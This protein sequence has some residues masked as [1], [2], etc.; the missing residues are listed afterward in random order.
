MPDPRLV[1]L[2]HRLRNIAAHEG[3]PPQRVRN[4]YVFQRVL[5]RLARDP[6]WVLK[7]GFSLELRLGLAARTTKDLDLLR[8]DVADLSA[9]DLQDLLDAALDVDLSDD[10]TFT[11]R[12]PRQVRAEDEMPSTWRVVVD[13][14]VARR[15]FETVTIDV[16]TSP[17]EPT[18]GLDAVAVRPVLGGKPFSVRS[19]DLPRHAAEKTHAYARIY[20]HDRPSSR[21]KDLVDLALLVEQELLEPADYA[22]AVTGVFAERDA[23][24]PPPELPDPPRDWA[25]PFAAMAADIGLD[26]Q[27]LDD[28]ATLVQRFY[29]FAFDRQDNQ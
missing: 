23:S 6:R 11:V 20:A 29:R 19:V 15:P 4:R 22:R 25:V 26:Q 5:A 2:T 16:V 18:S 14:Q 3:V 9:V 8:W 21:V 1:S 27:S 10:C 7:G 24:A 17:V 12:R 13:V 28:A